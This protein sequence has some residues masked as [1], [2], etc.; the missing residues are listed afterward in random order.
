MMFSFVWNGTVKSGLTSLHAHSFGSWTKHFHIYLSI[1][2]GPSQSK[3][4]KRIEFTTSSWR[5]INEL[6]SNATECKPTQY[7][8]LHYMSQCNAAIWFSSETYKSNRSLICLPFNKFQIFSVSISTNANFHS[9]LSWYNVMEMICWYNVK[10]DVMEMCSHW[11]RR[12]SHWCQYTWY[13][14]VWFHLNG[15]LVYVTTFR[16]FFGCPICSINWFFSFFVQ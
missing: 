1:Q 15:V 7:T 5:S 8:T 2:N 10:S 16:G 9:Q 13:F 12:T 6:S 11:W 14:F 3:L 4:I